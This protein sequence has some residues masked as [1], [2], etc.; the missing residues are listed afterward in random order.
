MVLR[1]SESE[2]AR[3][4]R[5]GWVHGVWTAEAG[6]PTTEAACMRCGHTDLIADD[7]AGLPRG[8]TVPCLVMPAD[9]H[10]PGF[11]DAAEHR[12]PAQAD[13]VGKTVAAVDFRAANI[14][15][16]RFTDGTEIAIEAG[17]YA[18]TVCRACAAPQMWRDAEWD[19]G[20]GSL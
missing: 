17:E 13:F 5:C 3:C 1:R 16:F 12:E 18:M 10:A 11:E 20:A 4:K 14:W 6:E 19:G 7:G 8:S 2:N 15:R 9:W